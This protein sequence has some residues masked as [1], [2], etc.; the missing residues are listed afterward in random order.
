[1]KLGKS[2]VLAICSAANVHSNF[3]PALNPA[4]DEYEKEALDISNEK[5]V[6]DWTERRKKYA[7]MVAGINNLWNSGRKNVLLATAKVMI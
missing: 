5:V 7:K 3:N 2:F 1:M 4:A 6:D